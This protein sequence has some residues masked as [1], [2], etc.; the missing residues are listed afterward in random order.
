MSGGTDRFKGRPKRM[1]KI[2]EKDTAK[3]IAYDD[4]KAGKE[5]R[6]A[7]PTTFRFDRVE[8][9]G[10]LGDLGTLLPIVVGMILI[11]QLSPTTVF[12]AFGLFYLLTGFYYRLPVPVQPLKAVGAIAIAFPGQIT[13]SVI[14][15][16][17]IIFGVI[18]LLL[19]LSGM[20]D[21][22]A[23]LFT[24][25][26]VRGIQLALG[27]IFLRKGIELIVSQE[28]FLS[29]ATGKYS[30]Y[31]VNLILGFLVFAMVLLLLDNTRIPAALGALVVGIVAGLA[32]GGLQGRALAVGPTEVRVVLPSLSDFYIAFFMLILPQIPLTIG[33]ACVG[34]ADTCSSLF[35]KSPLLS[36]ATAARFALSMGVVNL[37]AGF[38]GAVPMCHG[39]GGL[40][41]HYRFGARTGGAPIMIGGLFIIL[42]LVLGEL[43]L[44][45]LALIPNS[46]L[47][48]LL[49]FAGLELCPLVRSLKT[50]EEFFIALLIAGIALAVPNMAWAFG[51]G[52]LADL[53]IRRARVKI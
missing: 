16:A 21:R 52:I 44:T 19:S 43:G 6:K 50:N 23:R 11:N 25:P 32:L 27:L 49:V 45:I 39:T 47:G 53:L 31:H 42:A 35:P 15:A 38:F 10:S 3:E 51:I 34:T 29:G 4:G 1:A 17:G 30:E 40:A 22:I 41:A 20:L 7:L 46:V 2:N 12:L 37:P 5:S 14:G 13:E 36:R 8:L 33:N 48:V 26:V 18:L 9:A 28:I 24:Q